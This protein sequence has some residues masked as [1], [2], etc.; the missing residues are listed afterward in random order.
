MG[1]GYF[2]YRVSR[3]ISHV[4]TIA[5]TTASTGRLLVACVCRAELPEATS[6][7]SSGPAPTASAATQHD[8]VADLLESDPAFSADRPSG[9]ADDGS[10]E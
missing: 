5:M 1:G 10:E 4:S 7:Y 6:T 8:Y 3:P 2:L 9:D